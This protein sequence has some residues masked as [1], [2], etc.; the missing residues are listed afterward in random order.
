MTQPEFIEAL[1]TQIVKV[2]LNTEG[3]DREAYI[4]QMIDYLNAMI[5]ICDSSPVNIPASLQQYLPLVK[6]PPLPAS[7][8]CS[9]QPI[10]INVANGQSL[11]IKVGQ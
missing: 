6:M 2:K 1:T 8:P 3:L 5:A 7:E 9:D 4:N 11:T 10:V